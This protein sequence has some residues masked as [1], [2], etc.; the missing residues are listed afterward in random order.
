MVCS[1]T[2]R[3]WDK[4]EV[5]YFV[6]EVAGR[7]SQPAT[8][9]DSQDSSSVTI[10]VVNTAAG[11]SPFE[12]QSN[13]E[14]VRIEVFV[15]RKSNLK[16]SSDGEIRLDGVS[17]DIELKGGDES[18]NVRDVDG[19]LALSANEALVRVIGFRGELTSQTA[20]GDVFLEGDFRKLSAKATDGTVTLTVPSDANATL[21]SNTDVESDGV[22][23]VREDD[24]TWRVGKGG[25]RYNF[26]FNEGK[27]VVRSSAAVNTN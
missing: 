11:V 6:T 9:T 20:C 22:E 2:L 14:R 18:I 7:R 24:H 17:G 26:D 27:L 10:K 8:V 15:P 4:S 21:T 12:I 5:Q 1:Y 25:S 13:P 23:V 16:I 3:V 19:S